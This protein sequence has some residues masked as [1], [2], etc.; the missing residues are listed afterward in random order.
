MEIEPLVGITTQSIIV[1]GLGN[2]ISTT[3]YKK[4]LNN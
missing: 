3:K 4:N 1:V 2:F